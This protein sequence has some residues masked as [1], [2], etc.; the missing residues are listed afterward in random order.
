MLRRDFLSGAFALSVASARSAP[1]TAPQTVKNI[2]DYRADRSGRMLS[3]GSIQRAIDDVFK[4]GGG[5]VQIPPGTFLTGRIDLRSRVTLYLERG[6]T[7]LGS[8][9]IRDYA[10]PETGDTDERHLIF[11]KDAE[12]VTITGPGRID[13][14]GPSFWEPSGQPPSAPDEQWHAVASHDLKPKAS[15]RPSPMLY[16]VSCRQLR[17]KDVQIEN[18]PGWTVNAVNCDDVVIQGIAIRNPIDGPNTDGIDLTGCQNV[19]VT[20]CSVETGDDAVCLKSINPFGPEPRLIKNV[21][22]TNCSLITCCNGFKLGTDS[23]GGF[24]DITFSDSVVQNKDVPF[25]DR[26]ISG[27]ALEVVDGGWIDGV[28]VS[29]IRMQRTRAPIFIHM[30]NR[31]RLREHHGLRNVRIDDVQASDA[32]LASSITGLPG[33]YAHDISLSNIRVNTSLACRPDWVER[34]VPEKPTQ[35]PEAWMF[36]MLPASGLY[37]RHVRN[38]HLSHIEMDATAGEERPTMVFDDVIGA[39]VAELSSTPVSGKKPVIELTDC[40]EIQIENSAAPSGTNLF[41]G[42]TGE[43]SGGIILKEVDLSRAH[44]PFQASGGASKNAVTLN[45]NTSTPEEH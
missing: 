41:L 36:G 1:G 15:G 21:R 14:Q 45:S 27:I 12:D 29:G 10:S 30:G 11:A 33:T 7:L 2:L 40:R 20:H 28:T 13:G 22:V 43:N 9:A 8:T 16:F 44:K 18:S 37:A 38:L 24:E 31:Q 4:A 35:Y 26:V 39:T 23:A 19:V 32:L 34:P 3:T 5:T 25:K 42:V 6:G 17:I